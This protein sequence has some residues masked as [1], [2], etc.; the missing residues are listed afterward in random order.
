[1]T[2]KTVK[3]KNFTFLLIGKDRTLKTEYMI[4]I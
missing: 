3:Q 4:M 2:D 1:M